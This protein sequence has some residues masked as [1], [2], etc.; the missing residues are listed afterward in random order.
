MP[1]FGSALLA[2]AAE[3]HADGAGPAVRAEVP[4][5]RRPVVA[6]PVVV[7]GE[8]V[9]DATG[10]AHVPREPHH[11]VDF[12]FK[13]EEILVDTN[14]LRRD[15]SGAIDDDRHVLRRLGRAAAEQHPG[16]VANGLTAAPEPLPHQP[17]V[18]E[19][20]AVRI[21]DQAVASAPDEDRILEDDASR[22]AEQA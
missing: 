16:A 14:R 7:T 20:A 12:R 8:P 10:E 11:R 9:A 2:P 3:L 21:G 15:V 1:L 13:D 5:I 4:G 6:V 19:L 18:S 17:A 22:A